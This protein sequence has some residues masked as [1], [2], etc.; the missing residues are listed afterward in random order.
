MC[1][2]DLDQQWIIP[3]FEKMLY[4]NGPL[5]RLFSDLW[6]VE[7][8]PAIERV[9]R[10]SAGWI[11]R[12]MQSAAG[13]YYSTLDADSE[14][15]EGKFYIWTPD[16]VKAVLNADEYAIVAPHYGLTAPPNFEE[17]HW[18]LQVTVP[19]EDVARAAGISPERASA[20]MDSARAKLST[21]R[22]RRV[23]PARDEKILT[24]WNA[25]T[26]KGMAHAARVFA[27]P[28]WLASARRAADFIRAQLWRD[29]RLLASYKDGQATLNGYL[30]DYAFLLDALLELMQA[31]F[32]PADLTWACEIADV[33]LAQFE[34]TEAGGFFFVSQ[35]GRAHV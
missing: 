2:S 22:E 3:H 12:E 17:K 7:H 16:E 14:H 26:I 4:D 13:G 1:S 20:L 21:A 19:L 35:I 8:T 33:L 10:D 29:G 31:Q 9:V 11:I 6:L 32:N 5:L 25:L 18:H 30:D 15:E 27:E 23:R 24:A 28:Q 34:D